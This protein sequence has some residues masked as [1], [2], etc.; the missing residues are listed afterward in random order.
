[1]HTEL[2]ILLKQAVQ[3]CLPTLQNLTNI[4][5]SQHL[6]WKSSTEGRWDGEWRL[7]PDIFQVFIRAQPTID[8]AAKPFAESF[9]KYYPEFR[10]GFGSR[11]SGWHNFG[12]DIAFFLGQSLSYLWTSHKTFDVSDDM[13][14]ELV[15]E[16]ETF[17]DTR[18]VQ[19]R[20]RSI[21]LNFHSPQ[22]Q[23][24]NLIDLPEGL[25]IR[26][27]SESEVSDLYGGSMQ[28]MASR[29]L[30]SRLGM[31]EFCIEGEIEEHI[32]LGY[33]KEQDLVPRTDVKEKLDK[34]MLCLRTFKKG[35]VGYTLI[36]YIPITFCPL[37]LSSHGYGDLYVPVDIYE[38][39]SE[40]I[41][42]LKDHARL[43][44]SINEEAMHL[45][46]SRLADAECRTNPLDRILDAVIG[47]EALLLTGITSEL[48]FRFSLNYAML[49]PQEQR[50]S[51]FK[52]AQDI[53]GLRSKIAHGSFIGN[54]FKIEGQ[55]VPISDASDKATEALRKIILN[56][57]GKQNAPY[58]KPEFWQNRYFGLPD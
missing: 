51:A 21:L 19:L 22:S 27:L 26:R 34:A 32:L 40:E 5:V 10:G 2:K 7:L 33:P 16:F 17:I 58:K 35:Y 25:K 57:L 4:C 52:F 6:V 50:Q 12:H 23:E 43:I 39:K 28:S 11:L 14:D 36:Q 8:S 38:V 53:Y 20:F 1:M 9:A 46:C 56:F 3:E 55:K 30:P 24:N 44:F 49:F 47:M 13:I 18:T 45:A 41:S 48:S 42:S 37:V 31:H 15:K 54:E 29:N